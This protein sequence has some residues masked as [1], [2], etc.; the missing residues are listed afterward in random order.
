L[1]NKLDE[2]ECALAVIGIH[3]VLSR[4]SGKVLAPQRKQIKDYG[5]IIKSK[6]RQMVDGTLEC[7]FPM[8]P[9]YDSLLR[10]LSEPMNIGQIEAM[11]KPLGEDIKMPFQAIV[12]NAYQII[13]PALPK[14]PYKTMAGTKNLPIDDPSFFS[15]YWTYSV[16]NDPLRVIELMSAA[17]LLRSQVD[18]VKK[19]F[20]SIC[21]AIGDAIDIEIPAHKA[22]NRNFELT[23][24]AE[25]GVLIWRGLPVVQGE[26]Q[27]MYFDAN[28]EK[29]DQQ[30]PSKSQ[31]SNTAAS[32]VTA[33]GAVAYPKST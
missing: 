4:K 29:Q 32:Q 25:Q 10:D 2:A 3:S 6:V 15:F 21:A 1:D 13:Q 23:Y 33:A 27:S 22:K 14:N 11:I 5:K 24:T 18:V 17:S 16:I 12:S 20:P 30:E 31:L 26:Y 28:K 9:N 7:E 8:P 19:I